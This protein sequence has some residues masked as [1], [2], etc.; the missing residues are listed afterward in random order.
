MPIEFFRNEM[1]NKLFIPM[2]AVGTVAVTAGVVSAVDWA[3]FNEAA[4][5]NTPEP[6]LPSDGGDNAGGTGTDGDNTTDEDTDAGTDGDTD[7]VGPEPDPD[8]PFVFDT[9]DYDIMGGL[10][11]G[12]ITEQQREYIETTTS[13]I[14][15]CTS[16]TNYFM[17][18]G[19]NDAEEKWTYIISP[20]SG[21]NPVKLLSDYSFTGVVLPD[22]KF[23]FRW[24]K[25]TFE[26]EDQS[27]NKL[28]TNVSE[29]DSN[30]QY[31][32][33]DGIISFSE[34]K[35]YMI[36]TYPI[37]YD[38]EN[39]SELQISNTAAYTSG[40]NVSTNVVDTS[41]STVINNDTTG[42]TN[43][44]IPKS[45]IVG[46]STFAMISVAGMAYRIRL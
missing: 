12:G 37:S 32:N 7:V 30:T 9:P 22:G 15:R 24:Y 19:F 25:E 5:L 26:Y 36:S 18:F 43:R 16:D 8:I 38:Y 31:G 41:D 23:G 10:N 11:D 1:M 28:W 4:N 29:A 2:V 45:L 33:Q 35:T 40:E 39:C 13:S 3:P 20:F 21:D 17:E 14:I 27:G 42:T 44:G 46:V 34:W 6:E